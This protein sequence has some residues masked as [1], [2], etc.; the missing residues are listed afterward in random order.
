[1]NYGPVL[2]FSEYRFRKLNVFPFRDSKF[3]E[4]F[5]MADKAKYIGASMLTIDI[6]ELSSSVDNFKENYPFTVN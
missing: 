5:E 6:A 3:N 1:M 2:S 4:L